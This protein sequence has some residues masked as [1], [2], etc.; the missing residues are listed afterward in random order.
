MPFPLDPRPIQVQPV[1]EETLESVRSLAALKGITLS[2]ELAPGAL[3]VMADPERLH[4]VI[5]NLL[6]NAIKFSR[7][8]E[9]VYLRTSQA[10]G[11]WKLEVQDNGEGIDPAVL[12]TIFDGPAK[13]HHDTTRRH[14]GL[15]LGL[16][17]AKH[18]IER[19]GGK[20][21]A[22]SEGV[23]K[24]SHLHGDPPAARRQ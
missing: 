19:Q 11:L 13:I 7:D 22:R 6:S 10:D 1:I 21:E 12:P 9:T 15:G 24:G 4:Q 16:S 14:A 8:E 23:G 3:D 18:L 5:G 17:I 20:I 2:A